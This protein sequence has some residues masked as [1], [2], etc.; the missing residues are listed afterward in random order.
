M[1]VNSTQAPGS[2]SPLPVPELLLP[3]PEAM[4][5]TLE[6]TTLI[7]L[8]RM[9]WKRVGLM[10]ALVD[11][12]GDIMMLEHNKSDKNDAGALGPLG[13]T[14]KG[15]GPYVEQPLQTLHRGIGEELS[16]KEPANLDLSMRAHG[17][18]TIN[19]WPVG[20]EYPDDFACAISFPVFIPQAAK[21][22]LLKRPHG[23]EETNRVYFMSPDDIF[24]HDNDRL[25]PGVKKW[26][27]QLVDAELLD[28]PTPEESAPVDFS[29]LFEAGLRDIRL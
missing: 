2:L 10:V 1:S 14:T 6:P 12:A 18:W 27:E 24:N 29:N 16:V 19:Q 23:T 21:L 20:R 25:R 3:N 28:V 11:E 13:E 9:G 4:L 15:E 26:L 17:G 7:E 22:R 5:P 8:G